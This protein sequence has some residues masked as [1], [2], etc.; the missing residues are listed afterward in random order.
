[1]KTIK[2]FEGFKKSLL[3][4]T[5]GTME[6]TFD[7]SVLFSGCEYH[8]YR[9]YVDAIHYYNMFVIHILCIAIIT[10]NQIV[11]LTHIRIYS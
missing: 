10:T 7:S 11:V 2:N 4:A 8:S 5:N 3:A 6:E 9:V 1:M